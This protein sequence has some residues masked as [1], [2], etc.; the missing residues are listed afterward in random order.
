MKK[1]VYRK[2]A[3]ERLATADQLDKVMKITSPLSWL[4]LFGITLIIISVVIWSFVGSLPSTVTAN[5]MIVSSSTATNTIMANGEGT[6]EYCVNE[7]QMIK[8]GDIV[9]IITPNSNYGNEEIIECRSDQ[10]CF[11]STILANNGAAVTSGTELMRIRPVPRDD[12]KQ[13]IV[14]YV[15]VSDIGKIDFEMT[16][17]ITLTAADSNSYGHMLGRVI[18]IDTYATSNQGIE[19]VLGSDNSMASLFVKEGGV[20]AVTLE[21][22]YVGDPPSRN[23]YWWSNEK[24]YSLEF[25]DK[26]MCTV[27]ITTKSEMPITKLF[28][29]LKDFVKGG[30][31]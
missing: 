17:T 31:G 26:M 25:N 9:A 6:V 15:P 27:K 4:A 3:L 30:R 16:A 22:A 12:Q 24:G 7:G 21:L 1:D 8:K 2:A 13:V 29:K 20:C 5:G 18:N 10:M 19:A 28:I 23:G 11:V 14:C